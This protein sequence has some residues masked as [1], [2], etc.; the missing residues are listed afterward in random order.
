MRAITIRPPYIELKGHIIM[1]LPIA[2][3]ERVIREAGVSRISSEATKLIIDSAESYIKS[4]ATRSYSYATH[5][6]RNTLKDSDVRA[7]LGIE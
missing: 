3:T 4:L 1:T 7:A 5:A 6:G 2:T